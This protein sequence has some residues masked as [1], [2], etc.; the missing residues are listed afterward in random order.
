MKHVL[1][2][3][4]VVMGVALSVA[5][6]AGDTKTQ[7]AGSGSAP[8]AAAKTET[9]KMAA[10]MPGQTQKLA[11]A[12]WIDAPGYPAGVKLSPLHK[13]G[14]V[15][16]A[17]LKFP[18]GIK[19]PVHTHPA[20]HIATV[21]SGNGTFAMGADAKGMAISAGDVVMVPANT[22]HWIHATSE[23]IVFGSVIGDDAI[24]Y[25]NASDDPRKGQATS[26]Q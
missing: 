9:A 21:V 19:V 20:P 16:Y 8:A 7:A 17:Y 25:V 6:F 15:G 23:V 12:K 14:N 22:P 3:G 24:V 11:D 10:A 2:L 4:A 18:A 26:T 13:E 5:S 1:T